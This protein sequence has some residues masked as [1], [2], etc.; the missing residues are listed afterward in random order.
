MLE[1]EALPQLRDPVMVVALSGWVD[2]GLAGGGAAATAVK[3]RLVRS[4]NVEQ[5][6]LSVNPATKS[7]S[8]PCGTQWEG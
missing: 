6:L 7:K 8:K 5:T 2:A 3:A 4:C 1:V